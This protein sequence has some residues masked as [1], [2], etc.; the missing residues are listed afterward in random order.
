MPDPERSTDEVSIVEIFS[1]INGYVRYLLSFKTKILLTSLICLFLGLGISYLIKPKYEG[2][3]S[4]AMNEG[5]SGGGGGL[6]AY[7]GIAS[8]FGINIGG[9]GGESIFTE[10]NIIEFLKSR[11]MIEKTMLSKVKIQNK[12]YLLVNYLIDSYD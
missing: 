9:M 11:L 12:D 1:K 8:Q 5:D 2:K 10:E 7:A 4:F 3:L 6:G